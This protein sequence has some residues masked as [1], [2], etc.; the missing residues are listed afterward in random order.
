MFLDFWACWCGPCRKSLP[1]YEQMYRELADE[2]LHQISYFGS[3]DDLNLLVGLAF[4]FVAVSA[5]ELLRFRE[6]D[7]LQ[8]TRAKDIRKT[9]R[10]WGTDQVKDPFQLLD[11]TNVEN[12][13]KAFV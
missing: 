4:P 6:T 10:N 9:P 1:L 13:D 8:M 3:W 5:D 7:A 2:G 11:R 12:C